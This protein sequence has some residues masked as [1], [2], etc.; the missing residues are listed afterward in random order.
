MKNKNRNNA[1]AEL[2]EWLAAPKLS[3]SAVVTHENLVGAKT[4]PNRRP[5]RNRFSVAMAS[6]G[7]YGRRFPSA[8]CVC[9]TSMRVCLRAEFPLAGQIDG[10]YKKTLC[11]K[12]CQS[13]LKTS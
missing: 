2:L 13:L 9:G 12:M 8:F 10:Q 11:S 6:T 4:I 7:H 1:N 5:S 3:L